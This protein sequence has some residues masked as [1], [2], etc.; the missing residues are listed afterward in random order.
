MVKFIL[1]QYKPEVK[2]SATPIVVH[3]SAGAGRTGTFVA[4]D[5]T[6]DRL[7]EE[8]DINIFECVELMRA[9]RTQMV[10]NVVSYDF[11]DDL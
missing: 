8:D 1:H 6:I 7:A 11:T 4:I 5:T 2:D 3:C 10:Q 9:R